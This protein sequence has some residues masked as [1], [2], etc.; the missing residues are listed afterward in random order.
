MS[1]GWL[2]PLLNPLFSLKH[3]FSPLTSH[4]HGTSPLMLLPQTPP[5]WP[6]WL[7]LLYP[8]LQLKPCVPCLRPSMSSPYTTHAQLAPANNLHL[9]GLPSDSLAS[10]LPDPPPPAPLS[11]AESLGFISF[12]AFITMGK[13]FIYLPI[14]SSPFSH[15]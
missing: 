11:T 4:H 8:K 12:S 14:Q 7:P 6:L 13:Y 1:I 9:G 10:G 2:G 15:C 3:T 5:N